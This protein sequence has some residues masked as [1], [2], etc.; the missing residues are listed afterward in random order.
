MMDW[1]WKQYE[2]AKAKLYSF[3]GNLLG[4]REKIL[5]MQ[6]RADSVYAQA[7]RSGDPATIAA[8]DQLRQQASQLYA[9]QEA[10][11]QKVMDAK[12][13]ISET[14]NAASSSTSSDDGM[15]FLPIAIIAGSVAVVGA[16]IT[17]VVIHTQRVNY[18]NRALTDLE[19]KVLTPGQYAAAT[20]ALGS[21]G[22]NLGTILKWGA[23]GLVAYAGYKVIKG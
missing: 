21:W 8:A 16:A 1:A 23:I 6:D 11:E 10:V 9:E 2:I 20:G 3:I 14:D 19:Q 4:L 7:Q 22:G 12:D 17:A 13:K 5:Q 18:L 15:G